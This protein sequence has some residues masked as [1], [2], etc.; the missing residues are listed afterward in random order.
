MHKFT[1]I[2]IF[3]ISIFLSGS[4]QL[5]EDGSKKAKLFL[6]QFD[7]INMDIDQYGDPYDHY[8]QILT[9]QFTENNRVPLQTQQI[10]SLNKLYNR[11]I[12]SIERGIDKLETF[13]EFDT[14]YKVVNANLAY[15]KQQE[16]LWN[17][18]QTNFEYLYKT[19]WY[20]LSPNEQNAFPAF[21]NELKE[22]QQLSHQLGEKVTAL[23]Q[24]FSKKYG[25]EYV[26]KSRK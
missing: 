10:D 22:D 23:S 7:Q 3:L 17:K 9:K 11:Y 25:F 4:C 20:N 21:I 8:N 15:W 1:L 12:K 6:T 14:T 2:T 13:P 16:Y 5:K 24:E 18:M 19:G 26:V